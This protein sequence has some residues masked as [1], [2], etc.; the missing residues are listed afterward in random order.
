[1]NNVIL[2]PRAHCD[3]FRYLVLSDQNSESF[4]LLSQKM[5]KTSKRERRICVG[6]I[7]KNIVLPDSETD[8]CFAWQ[9]SVYNHAA[10]SD[11]F[12][13]IPSVANK[14]WLA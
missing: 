5:Q 7:N 3:I 10:L 11:L 2:V 13:C 6:L 1:M 9:F 4:T 12:C 8:F 14:S